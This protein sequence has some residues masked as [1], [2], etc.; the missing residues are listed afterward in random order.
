[1]AVKIH[2]GWLPDEGLEIGNFPQWVERQLANHRPPYVSTSGGDVVIDQMFDDC[3]KVRDFYR[4]KV[5]KDGGLIAQRVGNDRR[6][7]SVQ[8]EC[9]LPT[10]VLLLESP[11]M[12]EYDTS[13][14]PIAPAMG[15]T[16][17]NL[18]RQ[19]GNNCGSGLNCVLSKIGHKICNGSRIIISNPVQFQASLHMILEPLERN[20]GEIDR[21]TKRTVTST[22]WRSLWRCDDIQNC[23]ASRM[24]GYNPYIVINACTGG[25]GRYGLNKDVTAFLANFLKE[26]GMCCEIYEIG[27]PSSWFCWKY[28]YQW[29]EPSLRL[30]FP[31]RA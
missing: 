19:T 10:I 3:M 7:K 11:H 31:R 30:V 8:E 16:G 25:Q 27:H 29:T 18:D 9:C 21:G 23:F 2:A 26:R 17:D 28:P 4:Y 15:R 1:M 14:R 22:V 12:G 13:N 6:G 20:I 24:I 5:E